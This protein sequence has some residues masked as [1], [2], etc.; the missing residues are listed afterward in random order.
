[1]KQ[2]LKIVRFLRRSLWVFSPK[3]VHNI[4]EFSAVNNKRDNYITI[5]FDRGLYT[6]KI[7][8]INVEIVD[9]CWGDMN[10]DLIYVLIEEYEKDNKF[11]TVKQ[12]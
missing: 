3:V 4:T 7:E 5:I 10:D 11:K 2:K 6:N 12:K 8:D 9:W 1:M